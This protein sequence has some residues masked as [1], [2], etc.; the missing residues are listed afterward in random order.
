MLSGVLNDK[1]YYFVGQNVYVLFRSDYDRN[2]KGFKAEFSI[3]L[4]HN[5]CKYHEDSC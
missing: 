2:S 5:I 3:Q 4:N 1:D